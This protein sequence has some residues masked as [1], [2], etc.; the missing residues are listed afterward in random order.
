MPQTTHDR[1][2]GAFYGQALGDAFGMPSELWSRTRVI[3]HFGW[4]DR[5]L[6]GPQ[7]NSAAQYFVAGQ[8]TD[9]TSMAIAVADSIIECKGK[10]DPAS[11]GRHI[12]SWAENFDAFSKNILGPTSKVA[13]TALRNSIPIQDIANL[14]VTNGAAMRAVTLGCLMPPRPIDQFVLETR[15]ASSA[16][17]KSDISVA[18]AVVIGWAI[19]S[20]IEGNDWS[21]TLA[22]LPELAS[23]TQTRFENTFS[24]SL[25]A[26]IELAIEVVHRT[27]DAVAGSQAIYD[28]IGAGTNAIESVPAAIA[29]VELSKQDPN[30]CA[31]LCANLG[32]DTDTIGAMATAI[33]GSISGPDKI[34]QS[35]IDKMDAVN[36]IDFRLYRD[37][38]AEYRATRK[39]ESSNI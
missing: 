1:I 9:D 25:R 15:A 18:A 10:I 27:P 4:I 11:I 36:A 17:H 20:S 19:S 21:D 35:Y 37:L 2:L 5:F 13:L 29:M 39:N 33:C 3:E 23:A 14:G 32:G 7:E 6:D 34:K 30:I 31:E 8:I 28:L 12:L 22:A 26:R 24:A 16:T 38:F